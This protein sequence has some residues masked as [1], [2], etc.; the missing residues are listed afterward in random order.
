MTAST[1]TR[2]TLM[3][4][5]FADPVAEAQRTFRAI[6]AALGEPARTVALTTTLP[7]ALVARTAV[8]VVLTL[9]DVDTPLW[10]SPSLRFDLGRYVRFHCGA[11]VVDDPADAAFA[12]AAA[13]DELPP[14][15]AFCAGTAMSPERSTTIVIAVADFGSGKPAILDGPGFS[16]PRRL[17]PAGFGSAMWEA[18]G[19]NQTR[20][21]IGVDLVLCAP[22]VIVG[23]P[24]STRVTIPT[25]TEA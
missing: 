3:L 20:F 18:L 15:S 8:A 1:P 25:M 14:L 9:A 11:R 23:L 13:A 10:L 17:A 5:G 22:D 19:V 2:P 12:L 24:R 6:L 16:A 21:P 7:K 4:D